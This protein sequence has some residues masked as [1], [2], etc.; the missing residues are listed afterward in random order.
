DEADG[1][2]GERLERSDPGVRVG[3]EQLGE[4]EAGDR[5]VEEE[6]VP[7]DGG[8]NGGGNDGAA[9]LRLVVR[10]GKLRSSDVDGGHEQILPGVLQHAAAA[11]R[12]NLRKELS[13]AC[14]VPASQRLHF[15][16]KIKFWIGC[17]CGMHSARSAH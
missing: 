9:K 17:E 12:N 4:D 2:D 13:A 16:R 7:L 1:I 3:K 5:A 15:G 6:I 11:R 10:R 14:R 8:A